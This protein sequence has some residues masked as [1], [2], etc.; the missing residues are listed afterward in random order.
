MNYKQIIGVV[1]SL[2]GVIVI[3]E[4]SYLMKKIGLAKKALGDAVSPFSKNPLGNMVGD[5]MQKEASQYDSFVIGLLILGIVFL[6][7]G[8]AMAY[9][10]RRKR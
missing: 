2:L 10:L 3:L 8:L 4:S 5:V 9:F 1:M 7:C 6:A